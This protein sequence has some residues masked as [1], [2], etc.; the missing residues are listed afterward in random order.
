MTSRIALALVA[1]LCVC[2]ACGETVVAPPGSGGA[3]SSSS[4][5]VGGGATESKFDQYCEARTAAKAAASCPA[6]VDVDECKARADCEAILLYHPGD[7]LFDCPV[8]DPCN[9]SCLGVLLYVSDPDPVVTPADAAF[10]KQCVPRRL[11]CKLFEDLCL[12]GAL[13]KDEALEKMTACFAL[14]TCE[15]VQG[16][17]AT[18]YMRC[19]DV[20]Y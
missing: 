8:E 17:I 7:P 18:S 15:E 9:T 16:C 20:I 13:F 12:A 19:A 1:V 14:P 5:G 2:A 10:R 3:G 11:E 6:K 4:S